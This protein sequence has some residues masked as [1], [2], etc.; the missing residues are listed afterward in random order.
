MKVLEEEESGE[1]KGIKEESRKDEKEVRK[2]L[3]NPKIMT[4][5]GVP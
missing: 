1:E 5:A 2:K 4:Y 3:L